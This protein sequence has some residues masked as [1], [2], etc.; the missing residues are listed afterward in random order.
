MKQHLIYLKSLFP[1]L[2]IYIFFNID[3]K[4]ASIFFPEIISDCIDMAHAALFVRHLL[5]L[6]G[7]KLHLSAGKSSLIQ[8]LP[9]LIKMHCHKGQYSLHGISSSC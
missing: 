2:E 1:I 7:E 3:I 8:E 6:D 9:R 5:P 4:Y